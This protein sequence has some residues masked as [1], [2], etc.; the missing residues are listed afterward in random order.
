M[1]AY[2]VAFALTRLHEMIANIIVT[3]KKTMILMKFKVSYL[4]VEIVQICMQS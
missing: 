1:Y 3:I 4:S 2:G